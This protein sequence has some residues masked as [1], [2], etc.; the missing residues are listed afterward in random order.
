VKKIVRE[1]SQ[2]DQLR[3]GDHETTPT[4]GQRGLRDLSIG[5]TILPSV[6]RAG[7]GVKAENYRSALPVQ[8]RQL[9]YEGGAQVVSG[10]SKKKVGRGPTME[11]SLGAPSSN[12]ENFQEARSEREERSTGPPFEA[13][14][15]RAQYPRADLTD[16]PKASISRQ[17]R[18]PGKSDQ[19]AWMSASSTQKV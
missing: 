10:K 2:L 13:R 5:A 8:P 7:S 12:I 17:E 19:Q 18:Q 11:T 3:A 9:Q 1:L 14:Q 15:E 6:G 16:Q 4:G